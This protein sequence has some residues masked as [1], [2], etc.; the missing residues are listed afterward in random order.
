MKRD[1]KAE[2]AIAN[3]LPLKM[4][5]PPAPPAGLGGAQAAAAAATTREWL[6]RAEAEERELQAARGRLVAPDPGPEFGGVDKG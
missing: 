5:K 2:R 6:R 4:W 3:S 1:L